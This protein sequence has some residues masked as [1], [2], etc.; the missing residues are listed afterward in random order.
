MS[1]SSLPLLAGGN[2]AVAVGGDVRDTVIVTGD[3][4]I[5]SLTRRGAFSFQFLSEDFRRRQAATPPAPF[6]DGAV[7]NWANIAR[8]DDAHRL[9]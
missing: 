8:G 5:I 1:K 2:E 3:N 4:N 9:K 7:P 6:Y